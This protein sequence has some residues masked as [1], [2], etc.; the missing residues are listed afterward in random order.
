MS[1]RFTYLVLMTIV[2]GNA[3]CDLSSDHKTQQAPLPQTAVS[4]SEGS[5]IADSSIENLSRRSNLDLRR[6]LGHFR[7]CVDDRALALSGEEQIL[8]TLQA[9]GDRSANRD[10]AFFYR[11]GRRDQERS[12]RYARLSIASGY[13]DASE[14]LE[15]WDEDTARTQRWG[16][17]RN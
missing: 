6:L 11:Y 15:E 3:A 4:G 9:R 12:Q 16:P 10:L 8:L 13:P 14:I 5:C 2:I 17:A 7:F 1:R